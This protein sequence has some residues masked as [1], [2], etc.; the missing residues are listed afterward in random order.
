M[1]VSFAELCEVLNRDKSRTSPLMDSGEETGAMQVVRSGLHLREEDDRSFWDD[2][3][4]LCA[5]PDGLASLLGVNREIV[6]SWAGRIQDTLEAIDKHDQQAPETEDEE[7]K[8]LPTGDNG[9]VTVQNM[10]MT[11]GGA[12]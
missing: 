12:G 10:G 6:S 5:N 3:V 2:F 8:M 1:P 7:E 4:D 9:A 11:P